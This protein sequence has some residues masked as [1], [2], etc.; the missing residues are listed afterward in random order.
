MK[1]Q[2]SKHLSRR[3]GMTMIVRQAG[4]TLMETMV[5]LALSLVVITGM[6]IL[7]ANS[8]GTANRIIHMSQLSD[9]LRNAMSMMT[10]DVRRANYSAYALFCYG[11]SDCGA[12]DG[13]SPQAGNI[14]VNAD[15]DCFTFT[16]DRDSDGDAATDDPVGGFRRAEINGAGVIQMWTGDAAPNCA[17][18]DDA[19]GWT[20]LTDPN[21]VNVTALRVNDDASFPKVFEESETESFSSIQRQ[22]EI[23]LEGQL[24]LEEAMVSVGAM[25]DTMV[26]R[27]VRDIIYVRNN[28]IAL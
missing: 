14:F 13:I 26:R 5:S 1:M 16:L 8:L 20:E 2:V 23:T 19:L 10:R 17:A 18:A 4:I 11:N 27:E 7:M 15:E 3:Q 6:V 12:S 21:V 9:E 28:Y 25:L 24:V 22:I